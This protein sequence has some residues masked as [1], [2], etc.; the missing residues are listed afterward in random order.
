MAIDVRRTACTLDCPDSCSLEVRSENGRLV[1]IEGTRLNP[2]TAGFI[3]SKVRR[4]DRHLYGEDR[5]LHPARRVGTKGEGRF[6]RLSWDSALD[7]ISERITE[8][9]HRR[10]AEAILPLSYGGSNGLLTQDTLD[11][12]FFHRLGASN[13]LRT[14]C[15]APSSSAQ[16]GLYG[17][18]PG[19][20]LED[21]EHADLIVIWGTNPSATGIHLIPVIQRARSRG[22]RL[23]V[24]DPRTIPLA[25]QADLHL[26]PRP[27]SDLALA[28]AL[29]RY[30]FEHDLADGEFLARHCVG[31]EELRRR[32]ERWTPERA[33]EVC[34]LDPARIEELANLYAHASPAAIRCGWGVERNR[35]GGSA[36]AAILALPAVAGKFGV[37]A[38]GYTMSNGGA[39]R[40]RSASATTAPPTRSINQNRVGQMLLEADPPIDLLFVYNHNPLATLPN[41]TLV[42][43]GLAREDLFTVVFDQVLTDTARY[44]D[45][46]LPATTFLEHHDLVRG[47]G[48]QTVQSVQP[49]ID[50]IGESRSNLEVFG[51]LCRRFGFDRS[52]DGSEKEP[53]SPRE[54]RAAVLAH[55][56][57]AL[58]ALEEGLGIP[59]TGRRPIQF[60]DVF[61]HTPDRKVH[62][63]PEALDEEAPRGLYGFGDD[64]ATDSFPLALISPSSGALI[65]S[66]FGQLQSQPARLEIHPSDAEPRGLREGDSVHVRSAVGE[67]RCGWRPNPDLRPGVVY[68][69]KGLWAKSTQN[70]STACA[71]APDSLADLGGGACFN[72]ARVEVQ[73]A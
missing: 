62:L 25:K 72:D 26:A 56:P 27:G 57:E 48:T 30:L 65:S 46:V 67:I 3:C 41:Q 58:A 11:A 63:L 45:V 70:G 59:S 29:V 9:S 53:E 73:R 21:Y 13:L 10:G 61:P 60:V 19:V 14:V 51:E 40:L 24:V 22:A 49:V 55:E 28:L 2:Y 17:S 5:L 20:A 39:W 47:Y 34:D 31:A 33:A 66:T 7:L 23:V 4:I 1:A 68:L 6:E 12:R 64:P 15:A 50:P 36:V 42:R 43:Q 16:R 69:P 52:G 8:V 35:N 54:L 37:R 32:A 38:G 18:M 44:A 71:V